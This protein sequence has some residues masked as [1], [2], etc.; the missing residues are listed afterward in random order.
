MT[1]SPENL[2]HERYKT[3]KQ[4]NKKVFPS[5]NEN[6]T[7]G[8]CRDPGPH[9]SLFMQKL[10]KLKSS[11]T[12]PWWSPI[13]WRL[14]SSDSTWEVENTDDSKCIT[15]PHSSVIL[16]HTSLFHDTLPKCTIKFMNA[17]RQACPRIVICFDSLNQ[18]VDYQQTYSHV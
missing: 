14:W 17:S 9:V 13:L 10:F 3:L 12:N 16:S 7:L 2:A 15:S 18:L 8:T 1:Y 4:K 6:K 5:S 11:C